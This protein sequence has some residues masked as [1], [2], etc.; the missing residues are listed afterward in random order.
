[1]YE[2]NEEN[3]SDFFDAMQDVKPLKQD[4]KVFSA[5][6]QQTLA[7][8]LKRESLE[9][10]QRLDLNYLSIESVEPI[11]PLDMLEYKKDGVQEGVY[12]N[13]RLGKYKID[14]FLNIQ[15]CKFELARELVFDAVINGHKHGSRT[16]LI[17]HGIG[18]NAKPVP[19]YL[20]SYVNQWLKQMPEVLAFHSALKRHG[21][22]AAVYILLKKNKQEKLANRE[23]HRH[24]RS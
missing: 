22:L 11:A 19:A 2:S 3:K 23:L 24:K 8:Q 14:E 17:K 13:L 18:E 12:K 21:G 5:K 15:N 16:L 20:K 6:P 1:M 4:D 7:Q 10:A 9:K